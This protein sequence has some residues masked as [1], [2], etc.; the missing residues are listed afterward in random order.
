M[1]SVVRVMD[2]SPS[3]PR[4]AACGQTVRAGSRE[5]RAASHPSPRTGTMEEDLVPIE[6][7][8]LTPEQLTQWRRD[9]AALRAHLC[10]HALFPL[11][12]GDLFNDLK[13][14]WGEKMPVLARSA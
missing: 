14:R 3:G 11:R 8:L 9:V 4:L 10:E 5:P 2:A 1:R 12:M 13:Q 6:E 7:E